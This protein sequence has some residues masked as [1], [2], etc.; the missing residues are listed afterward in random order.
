LVF[1]NE[2]LPRHALHGESEYLVIGGD[3]RVKV[4]R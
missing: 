3:Y 1:F 4:L 2:L